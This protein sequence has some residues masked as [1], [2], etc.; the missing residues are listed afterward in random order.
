MKG[1]I[2][3]DIE[4]VAEEE[5]KKISEGHTRQKRRIKIRGREIHPGAIIIGLVLALMIIIM[6]VPHY[7]IKEDPEPRNIPGKEVIPE[8]VSTHPSNEVSSIETRANYARLMTPRD[9][10]IKDMATKI[11]T[12]S[13]PSVE[14]CQSKSIYYWVRDNIKYVADPPKGYLENP[15][16]VMNSGGSDCDGMAILLANLE[17]AIGVNTRLAFIP[18]HVYVQVKID[19]APNK[20][21]EKDG[22]ITMDP[23]CK[24]CEFGQVPLKT[25]NTERKDY[26]YLS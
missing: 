23:T 1:D 20:Y 7:G 6:V 21:K 25:W 2:L 4:R 19:E 13:C 3:K 9:P 10:A 16:Q 11:A 5:E 24:S 12:Q 26:L 17:L 8:E 18:G 14:V 22:W 15:Y